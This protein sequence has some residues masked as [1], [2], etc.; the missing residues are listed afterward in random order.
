MT[1]NNFP[2]IKN[3]NGKT[4]GKDGKVYCDDCQ[5]SERTCQICGNCY[6]DGY[7]CEHQK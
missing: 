3:W 1:K 2:N 5:S 6:C 7:K 4:L